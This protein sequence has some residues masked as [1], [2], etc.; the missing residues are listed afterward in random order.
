M[1]NFCISPG[2]FTVQLQPPASLVH[3]PQRGERSRKPVRIPALHHAPGSATRSLLESQTPR[4][5]ESSSHVPTHVTNW[6]GERTHRPRLRQR[7]KDQS[8]QTVGSSPRPPNP[9]FVRFLFPCNANSTNLRL[10]L[11]LSLSRSHAHP[12]TL[13]QPNQTKPNL[14]TTKAART[15]PHRTG[16]ATRPPIH[17]SIHSSKGLCARPLSTPY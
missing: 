6:N 17:P 9:T 1:D 15:A 2:A 7:L 13:T 14:P 16:C 12:T 8:H 3:L 5:P 10:G 11:G 4:L